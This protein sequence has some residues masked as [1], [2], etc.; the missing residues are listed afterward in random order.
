MKKHIFS[1][2]TLAV[3]LCATGLQASEG[4][5]VGVKG[6]LNHVQNNNVKN[7]V[8]D[9]QGTTT[10]ETGLKNGFDAAASLGWKFTNGFRT[11]AEFSY[12]KNQMDDI[13]ISTNDVTVKIDPKTSLRTMA[14]MVNGLYD[15]ELGCGFTPYVGLG[16]GYADTK[17]D[18][19]LL[20]RNDIKVDTA[21]GIAY[22][23]VAGIS[24]PIACNTDLGVEYNYFTQPNVKV[25]G[26][27]L[28]DHS[29]NLAVRYSF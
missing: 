15:L 20:E 12:R 27:R 22:Q 3:S 5:Y 19:K 29:V 6:G 18:S 25:N 13:K 28:Q 24:M 10:F 16:L 7:K 2:L 11:E 21:R 1:V 23:A 17:V 26:K 8:E 4:A 9:Q 14:G